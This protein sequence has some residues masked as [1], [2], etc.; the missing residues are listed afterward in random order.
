MN[1]YKINTTEAI[2]IVLTTIIIHT[3]LSLPRNLLTQTKSATIINL[4]YVSVIAIAISYFIYR[5]LKN[6]PGLD[7]IDISELLGGKVLKNILGIIFILFFLVSSG[8]VLRN[9]CEILKVIYYPMT[10]ITFII[11]IFILAVC[12]ENNFNFNTNIKSN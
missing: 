4:I 2:M 3:I 9:F 11:L 1:T 8:M 10:N 5:L 6:F 12:I 7:I